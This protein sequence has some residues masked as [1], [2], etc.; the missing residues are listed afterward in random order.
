MRVTVSRDRCQGH[1]RC[2]VLCPGV[3]HLDGEGHS[4]ARDDDVPAE[5]EDGARRAL[6]NCPE[7]AISVV[8]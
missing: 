1:A 5:L 7:G 2:V 8:R 6:R 4:H 3:F